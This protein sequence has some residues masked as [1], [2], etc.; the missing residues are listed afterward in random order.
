MPRCSAAVPSRGECG[1]AGGHRLQ[2]GGGVRQGPSFD[3]TT[4]ATGSNS[5]PAT[6]VPTIHWG[7]TDDGVQHGTIEVAADPDDP[8]AGTF[9]LALARHLA[10][11]PDQRIGSL[12]VNPGGPGAS[13]LFL[14]EQAQFIYGDELLRRFDIVA[15]DPRGTGSSTPAVQCT[16]DEDAVFGVDQTP[17]DAAQEAA[18]ADSSKSFVDGCEQHSADLLA[19]LG[20]ADAARDMDTIR[21]ALGEETIS[22]FGFSYGSELGATW[23]TM[24]PTT[25]RAVV[26]DGAID[27]T[28]GYL[29]MQ[30]DQAAGFEATFDTFLDA[31]SADS[32]C[33][34]HNGGH[35][36]T[37]FDALA[38]Q[39]EQSPI[40]TRSGR[41]PVNSGVLST[42]VGEA[43][44]DQAT[45]PQ[46]E[47]ALADAQDG[48]GSGLLDL[49]DLYY[50]LD[51]SGVASDNATEAY[52]A[53]ECPDDLDV[54]ST[55]QTFDLVDE[56]KAAAP[57]LYGSWIG[58]LSICSQWPLRDPSRV[59]IT[60]T[61]A[62]PIV[63]IGTT[64]DPA[65]PLA[66]TRAMANTL[67]DGRLIVVTAEQHTGYGVNDCVDQAVDD[68]LVDPAKAPPDEL[69]CTGD[70]TPG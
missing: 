63:V 2:H 62:G 8:A 25:V 29:Q 39:V 53:V 37:A 13:G 28:L 6:A 40:P 54:T 5:A 19:R 11:D 61:G 70:E 10:T 9:T 31:C 47:Q 34:F 24:F 22:Y 27:P 52:Y 35:A 17:D 30:L 50:S 23:A 56:F 49:Y 64:G 67:E 38:A 66:G 59:T 65:T 58:E 7:K 45:W 20:T 18:L 4:P 44:Y 48:D 36:D 41:P 33:A 26:L 14:A 43:L 15:F 69:A 16:D 3:N 1:R 42:A 32:G 12:L 55:S 46:L 21:Q 60:G 57:R 51:D 68:Y